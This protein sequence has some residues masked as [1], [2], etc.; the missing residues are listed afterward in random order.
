MHQR[1]RIATVAAACAAMSLVAGAADAEAA[2]IV[3]KSLRGIVQTGN[4]VGSGS[5]QVTGA[6]QPFSTERG[7]V[8]LDVMTGVLSFT[9]Q[10]LSFAGGNAIG[11]TGPFTM[12]R[13]TVLCDT[14]GSASGGN[15]VAIDTPM[16][17]L[18]A[19]GDA[20]FKGNVGTDPV[21]MSEPDIAFLVR[22]P[23]GMWVAYGAVRK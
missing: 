11:S 18:S 19:Q 10:G 21:C 1:R 8:K 15:S 22:N 4:L 20:K 7:G 3:W 13:G 23:N 9:L 5:G 12:V 14:D 2:T 17:A 16:V 6:G